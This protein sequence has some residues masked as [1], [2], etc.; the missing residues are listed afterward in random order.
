VRRL[1]ENAQIMAGAQLATR[2][3]AF[4]PRAVF[5]I[6]EGG[7][8][9]GRS[10]AASLEVPSFGIDLCYPHR[11]RLDALPRLLRLALWPLKEIAYRATSPRP[12]RNALDSLP[13]VERA[14]LV[15]DTASSGRTLRAAL[16][17]LEGRGLPRS[18][19]KVAV[20]RCGARAKEEVDE[21]ITDERVWISR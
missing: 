17:L 16:E 8:T 5:F 9:L 6:R 21:W 11:R 18:S 20:M 3:A 12:A 19:L 7:S 14:V 13:L 1:D 4:R 10:I 15:D 2:L